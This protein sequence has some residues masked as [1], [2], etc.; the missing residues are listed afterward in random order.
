VWL[1][2]AIVTQWVAGAINVLVLAPVWIQILHLLLADAAWILLVLLGLE[3]GIAAG[4]PTT[5]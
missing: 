2:L 4:E 1:R 5:S 3:A